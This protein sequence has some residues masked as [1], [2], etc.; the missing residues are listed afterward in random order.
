[1]R[2]PEVSAMLWRCTRRVARAL[3]AMGSIWVYAEWSAAQQGPLDRHPEHLCTD[4]PLSVYE[5]TLRRELR[6]VWSVAPFYW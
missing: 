5:R 3:A 4:V 6:E 1:M 2:K